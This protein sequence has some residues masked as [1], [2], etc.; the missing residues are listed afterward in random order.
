VELYLG[1]G[2]TEAELRR[3]QSPHVLHLATHGFFLPEINTGQPVTSPMLRS[4]LVLAGAQR[5]LDAWKK[6]EVVPSS[7][8]GIVTAEEIGMLNLQRTWLVVLSAC[9]TGLG[10]A[11]S[12][13]GVLG[14]RRGFLRAGAQNLLMT[15]WAVEDEHTAGLMLDFYSAAQRF[16]NPARALAEVQRDWL[17]RLRKEKGVAEA[18]RLAGPFILSFQGTPPKQD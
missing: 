2:A 13:E 9:D 17:A 6:G 10:E 7:N 16:G 5:T 14:L 4:G 12:G 8:D 1:K 15:L 11:R 18:C 3:V